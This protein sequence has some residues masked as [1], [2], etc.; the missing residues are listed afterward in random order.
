MSECLQSILALPERFRGEVRAILPE[1]AFL[2]RDREDA[3]YVTDAPRFADAQA[4]R[5]ALAERGFLCEMR[6][7]RMA[8]FSDAAR[9][10]ELEAR[11]SPPDFFCASLEKLR[12]LAPSTEALKLFAVG[13]RLL[14]HSERL[15][16]SRRARQLAAVC[17]RTR[18]GGAYACALIDF[19]LRREFER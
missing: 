14:E 16:Y 11:C 6:G 3:L 1:R 12:A 18:S 15:T 13:V 17:L 5:E 19:A 7:E 4:L 2:R 8:I 9:L 10:T